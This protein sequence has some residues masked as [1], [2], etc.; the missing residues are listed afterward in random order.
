MLKFEALHIDEMR[1]I[2]CVVGVLKFVDKH[3]VFPFFVIF[4]TTHIGYRDFSNLT[5]YEENTVSYLF[6]FGKKKCEDVSMEMSFQNDNTHI[7]TE[8]F[9]EAHIPQST[10]SLP[11][12][13]HQALGRRWSAL[14]DS[15]REKD[16]ATRSAVLRQHLL[17]VVSVFAM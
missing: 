8:R 15:Q 11:F 17:L 14:H 13:T 12:S 16:E 5:S 3:S 10:T 4:Q 7:G 2:F 1:Y 6:H 9:D